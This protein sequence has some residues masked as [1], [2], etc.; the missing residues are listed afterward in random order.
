MKN[1]LI[2]VFIMMLLCIKASYGEEPYIKFTGCDINSGNSNKLQG[3]E[4]DY[5]QPRSSMTEYSKL[6][7]DNI[8]TGTN[9]FS[10]I[11]TFSDTAIFENG[12]GG[13]GSKFSFTDETGTRLFVVTASSAGS[14]ITGYAIRA[15]TGD[16]GNILKNGVD[17][18]NIYAEK[19]QPK[20]FNI[21]LTSH[22]IS[23]YSTFLVPIFKTKYAIT[24]TSITVQTQIGTI[25]DVNVRYVSEKNRF[26]DDGISVMLES[27]TV[28]E[29]LK[30]YGSAALDNPYVPENYWL[31]LY[32]GLQNTFGWTSINIEYIR[33]E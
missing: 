22:T 15:P 14:A 32:I 9:N 27:I 33:T 4:A 29:P 13:M 1:V 31:Q 2:Y 6:S 23:A 25:S 28:P 8:W 12:I 5:F 21:V 30:D 24:I 3:Y 10:N 18:N 16:F 26:F 11:V 20:S 17:I 19:Y 7:G